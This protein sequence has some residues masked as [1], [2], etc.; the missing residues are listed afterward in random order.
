MKLISCVWLTAAVLT[1][2]RNAPAAQT[3]SVPNAGAPTLIVLDA[4]SSM[5]DRIKGETKIDIAK[6]AVRELVTSLPDDAR[7]G[8]VVYSHRKPGDCKDIELLIPPARLDRAAFI[9]AVNAIQPKGLTPLSAALEFAA[10]ALDYRK[11]PANV[12]LVSDGLETCGG[13]PCETAARL[14]AASLNLVVHAVAFDLSAAEAKSFAC[15]AT[16]TGGRFLQANDAA[17]LRDALYVAVA[18]ASVPTPAKT[19]SL[20]PEVI[21]PVTIKAALSV[22]AG[23]AFPVGWTGPD[24]TGDFLTIV[25]KGT[26]DG[27]DGNLAYTRQGSPVQLTALVDP[28]DAE[29]RYVAGRAHTILARAPIKITPVDVTLTAVAETVAGTP[30]KISWKGPNNEGDSITIVPKNTPDNEYALYANTREGSPL[31]VTAPME[32]GETEI[33][34]LS[35]QRS[36]VLARRPL[37]ILAAEISLTAPVEVVAGAAVEI[38]WKGPNNENDYLTIVAKAL[39]DGSRGA[40]AYTG[41]GSPV[42]VTAPGEAGVCEIRYMSGQGEKVLARRPLTTVAAGVA[43]VAPVEV[44]A[45]AAVE[46]AWK[47]PDNENDYVTIVA[48][49]LPDGSRGAIAYTG[50]GSPVR[51][52]APA[53]AGACE[54]RYMR[55][56]DDKVLARRPLKTIVAG[57]TLVAPEEAVAGAVVAIAWKG[58]N[59][60]ND[61]LTIVAQGLPD[62]ERGAIAYT[63]RGSPLQVTAPG[64]PGACEIRYMSGLDDKVLA[65]RAL[66]ISAAHVTLQAPARA[67]LGVPVSV[68]WTGPNNLNDYLTIVPQGTPDGTSQH[69]VWTTK[70]SPAQ[71]DPPDTAGLCEVRYV[72]GQSD[73]V[74]ARISIEITAAGA[75]P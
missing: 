26:P 37:K 62:G 34:Y 7:L 4:S 27:D 57:V 70:G 44:V 74:L 66:K 73:K 11:Q 65:R 41:R 12:I 52:T 72:S 48:K 35:G 28:G 75:G 9:A 55:G 20:P 60:E 38:A 17:S 22:L 29:L 23:M 69:L 10:K 47:G 19:A 68:E 51:V 33:R 53:E 25:P 43:L 24:N 14:K 49:A 5:R 46:I 63:G 36:H 56:L 16:A 18:V 45:G 15:I 2:A 32:T 64:E 59:N 61:Y 39:P 21:I 6:R 1:L 13:D 67:P 58:P 71:V 42:R 54:I 8:L 3:A 40:I 31:T 30:V 50:R